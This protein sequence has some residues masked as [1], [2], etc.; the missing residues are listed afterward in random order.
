MKKNKILAMSWIFLL[1]LFL[2]PS[3]FGDKFADRVAESTEVYEELIN[4]A[5]RGVPEYLLEDCQ[6]VLVIP[7]VVKAALGF[8][9]RSGNG[10]ASCRN[11]QGTWSPPSFVKFKGGSFGFQIG[12]QS[13]DFVLFV[14]T[15]KGAR[16]LLKSKF[17]LGGDASVAAG[18]VGRTAEVD[19]DVTLRAE[20]YAYARSK[21][22]FA[23]I[24]LEGGRLSSDATAIRKYYGKK[25][26][27]EV[28]LFQHQVPKMPEGAQQFTNLLP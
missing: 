12:V 20:I 28:I 22:L 24:S 8:G 4:A 6:C 11:E 27:P 17:M 14:M 7:H 19:T 21:G 3:L 25:I 5:D 10:I 9:G 2:T 13:S 1:G 26:E 23:G 15:E 16:A 18:P